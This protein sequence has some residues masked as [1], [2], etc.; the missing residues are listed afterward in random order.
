MLFQVDLSEGVVGSDLP[1]ESDNNVEQSL[2]NV[3]APSVI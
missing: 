2:D 1:H 3:H